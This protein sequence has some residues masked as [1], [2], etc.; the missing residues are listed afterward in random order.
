MLVTIFFLHLCQKIFEAFAQGGSLRQPHRQTGTHFLGEEEEVH[1]FAQFAVVALLGL[2][3]EYE[4]F[5]QFFLFRES[6][7]VDA[8]ELFAVLVTAPI[9]TGCVQQ[10]DGLDGSGVEKVRAR[11]R[12]VKLPLS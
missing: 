1:F 10:L 2:F 5:V 6:D 8:G 7:T 3:E 9:G 11:Q 12:S 4:V